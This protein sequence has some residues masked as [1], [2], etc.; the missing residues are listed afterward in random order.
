MKN[1]TK[2]TKNIDRYRHPVYMSTGVVVR[3]FDCLDIDIR[4]YRHGALKNDTFL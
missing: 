1:M 3:G 2:N 4:R